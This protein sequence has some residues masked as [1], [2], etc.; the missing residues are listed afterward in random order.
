MHLIDN[1]FCFLKDVQQ[2]IDSQ[3]EAVGQF[4]WQHIQ[5]DMELMAA[6]CGKNL[7]ECLFIVHLVL[8]RIATKKQQ[9]QGEIVMINVYDQPILKC[10]LPS[11]FHRPRTKLTIPH[12][13]LNMRHLNIF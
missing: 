11:S 5:A 7:D 1:N 3:P 9:N 13:I 12:H 4:L 2:L 6:S 8:Q 10:S